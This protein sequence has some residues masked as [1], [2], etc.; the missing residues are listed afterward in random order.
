MRSTEDILRQA[1]KCLERGDW[2]LVERNKNIQAL[3]AH[4]LSIAD[5]KAAIRQLAGTNYFKGPKKDFNKK[6]KG[7]I[8]EFKIVIG[9]K[10]FYLKLKLQKINQKTVLK[11][12]SFHK[13]DYA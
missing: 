12:L 13:D 3:I 9:G 8:Y 1:K 2:L 10:R 6:E 4:D 11:C 7:A 5:V